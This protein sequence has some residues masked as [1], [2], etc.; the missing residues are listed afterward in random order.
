MG[1]KEMKKKPERIFPH[2]LSAAS[3]KF[4][5]FIVPHSRTHKPVGICQFIKIKCLNTN[6]YEAISENCHCCKIVIHPMHQVSNFYGIGIK[7]LRPTNH[8]LAI[9]LLDS[10]G[11]LECIF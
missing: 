5:Y 11:T 6:R 2:L 7:I 4:I 10:F 1:A 9:D 3:F 8:N